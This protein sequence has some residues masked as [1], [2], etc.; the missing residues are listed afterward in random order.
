MIAITV[1]ALSIVLFALAFVAVGV[2]GAATRAVAVARD[3]F[4]VMADQTIG[5]DERESSVRRAS[6]ELMAGFV[7]IT[8]RTAAAA[9]LGL[10]PVWASDGLGWVR[11]DDVLLLMSRW[12]V[13]ATSTAVLVVAFITWRR[14]GTSR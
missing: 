8:T 14:F 7:S 3:A 1:T 11:T 12:D 5:D 2:V 4:A 13:L 10:L 6:L 9:A